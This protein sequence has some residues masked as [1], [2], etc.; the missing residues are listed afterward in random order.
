MV[1]AAKFGIVFYFAACAAG[2]ASEPAATPAISLEATAATSTLVFPRPAVLAPN[3]AFWTEA[4]SYYSEYQSVIHSQVQTEKVYMVLDF[5]DDVTRLG[6]AGSRNLQ[7]KTEKA[8]KRELDGHLRRIHAL[9]DKPE[10]LSPIE[11]RVYDLFADSDD[12][13]RFKDAIGTFRSQRGLKEKTERALRVSGQYLPKMEAIFAA[14]GL[15]TQLTRLPMVESSFN[16]EAYSKVG[17]AGMWQF[18]TCASTRRSTT[19]AIRGPR[20]RLRR[21]T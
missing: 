8:V 10:Q 12:P 14:E 1:R 2:A 9:R 15:P 4:F 6:A 7:S 5:R 19:G 13:D 16:T 20:P 18:C 17:A 11:R 21:A 3:V